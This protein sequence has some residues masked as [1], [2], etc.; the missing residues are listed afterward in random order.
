MQNTAH[1]T[2]IDQQLKIMSAIVLEIQIDFGAILFDQISK[3]V[4]KAEKKPM[5]KVFHGRLLSIILK[6]KLGGRIKEDEGEALNVH[7]VMSP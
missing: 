4:E 5:T 2:V 1:D 6:K 3:W 7:K